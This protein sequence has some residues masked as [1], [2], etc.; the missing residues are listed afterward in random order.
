MP[1]YIEKNANK[2][3][4]H[5]C[6]IR[7]TGWQTSKDR[8]T[9]LLIKYKS[10]ALVKQ[11]EKNRDKDKDTHPKN[12]YIHFDSRSFTKEELTTT[13]SSDGFQSFLSQAEGLFQEVRNLSV[14]P[15]YVISPNIHQ[16]I[17]GYL[18]RKKMPCK[19]QTM[20]NPLNELGAVHLLFMEQPPPPSPPKRGT[21]YITGSPFVTL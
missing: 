17:Y 8:A 20:T 1:V 11:Q 7:L 16:T 4:W 10:G 13:F 2:D 14:R 19:A 15:K 21:V 5:R 6:P 18:L 3:R 9:E 12:V